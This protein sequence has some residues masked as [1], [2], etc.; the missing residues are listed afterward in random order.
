MKL[1][2][3]LA[4]DAYKFF[5]IDQYPAKTEY[6]YSNMTPRSDKHTAFNPGYDHKAVWFGGQGAT[7]ALLIEFW[8]ETFFSKPKG[9]VM[10]RFR[11]RITSNF[12][13][14]RI[15]DAMGDLHDLGHLPL[16]IKALPEGSRVPMKVPFFTIT[17]THPDFG[18]VTNFVETPLS[19]ETWKP[20]T[21]ATTAYEY[22]R[23][24]EEWA[25]KTGAPKEFCAWQ[26]HDFSMRGMSNIMDA[27]SS[28]AGHLTSFLGTDTAPAMD[29]LD[30]YYSGEETFLGGSVYATE[31]SVMCMGGK[32]GEF[33]T[34]KRLITEVHP[35]G[36]VS[37]VSDTWDLWNVVKRGGILEQLKEE[38]LARK[39]DALGFAKVVIRPD[40]TPT[41]PADILCGDPNAEPGSPAFKG[42]AEC[43]WDIFGGTT[44]STGHKYLH[45]RIG[46][47]YGDSISPRM[48]EEIMSRLAAKG[49]AAQGVLGL[50]S[51]TYQ[52]VTRDTF[53]QALKATCGIVDGQGR[54]LF[55][56]P[57]TDRGGMKK[58]AKGL[59]RVEK[60]ENGEFVL[61]DQQTVE[62]EKLGLL[63]PLFYNGKMARHQTIAGI[64]T[65]LW[66]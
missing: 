22:R 45:E 47:I 48:Q 13:I 10:D 7:Q 32:D 4:T 56:D 3:P 46:F 50:G 49:F 20:L 66:G 41:T 35:T 31:H 28:G 60:D 16:L 17:N 53:G 63:Q 18:W 43:L 36:I 15:L 44:T 19:A 11:K 29:Y 21:T 34:F 61:F 6:V 30:Q 27:A 24:F 14:G 52:H 40:S 39:P 58:S 65:A 33:D 8:G 57:I 26:G 2:A 64:R 1:F 62:Q 23:T 54:E 51:Y 12:G 55:K 5:H 38:I 42:V 59:L 25:K 9:A 37:I